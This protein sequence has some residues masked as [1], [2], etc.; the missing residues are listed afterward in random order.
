MSRTSRA[1][2]RALARAVLPLAVVSGLALAGAAAAQATTPDPNPSALELQD[3]QLSR[4][5]AAQGMVLLENRDQ[6]L[7]MPKTG[8]VALFGVGAYKTVKGGT[9]SGAVNNRYTISVRQGLEN[10]GYDVTTSSA[11]WDAMV[12]AYDTKYGQ[13][14]NSPFGQ[15]VDYASV[16]QP[17]T[18]TSVQPTAHT[19]TAIY[20]VARNSGEGADRSSG[21]GD[22]QLAQVEAD[23]ITAI[24]K[25]YKH[26]I[27][28]LN[29]GGIVD[30]SFVGPDQRHRQGPRRRLGGRLAAVDEPG[31]SGIRQRRHEGAQRLDHTVGQAHRHLGDEVQLLPGLGDLRQQ[32]R[33]HRHRAV[34]RRHLRRVPLLRLVLQEHRF[35]GPGRRRRL[36]FGYG[37][38]YTN[39]SS[40]RSA[41]P[42]TCTPSRSR[43]G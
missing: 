32:R 16:E 21:P 23:D 37:L 26:V 1:R 34:Q 22:Y 43:R 42:P 27:V 30:T 3:A 38:S 8:T 7:P 10:A 40:S 14:S 20:V 41:S 31:R 28:V 17:L 6:A 39:F 13:S 2:P 35:S 36:P 11:Y 29:T 5:A 33:Q 9:G 12:N 25:T 19:D 4:S 24:G 15:T 18:A